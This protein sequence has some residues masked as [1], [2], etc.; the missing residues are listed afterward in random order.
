MRDGI[1][2]QCHRHHLTS[3]I[4]TRFADRVGHFA[5]FPQTKSNLT[6]AI[7]GND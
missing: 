5:R 1:A 7:T 6:F 3:G 4:L 2:S